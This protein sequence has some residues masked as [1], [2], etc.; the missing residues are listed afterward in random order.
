MFNMPLFPH[1]FFLPAGALFSSSGWWRRSTSF[2]LE[3]HWWCDKRIES[4]QIMFT[5][6]TELIKAPLGRRDAPFLYLWL[7]IR[8]I[9]V[10][11]PPDVLF[12]IKTP[13]FGTLPLV[14][15]CVCVFRCVCVCSIFQMIWMTLSEQQQQSQDMRWDSSL[16][17]FGF[18]FL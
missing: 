13:L 12:S 14:C 18:I 6:R 5:S 11:S 10:L 3:Y 17:G 4:E 15:V 7:M 2:C 9:S 1:A 16:T 8:V